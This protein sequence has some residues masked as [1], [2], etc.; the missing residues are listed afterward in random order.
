M[1]GPLASA[2]RVPVRRPWA[3]LAGL[4]LVAALGAPALARGIGTDFGLEQLLPRG[5][6]EFE[7][8]RALGER[9]GKD[10]GTVF[11]FVDDPALLTPLGARQVVA[12]SDA[13]AAGPWVEEVSG[14]AT[15]TLVEDEGDVLRVGPCLDRTRLDAPGSGA[16]GEA[17]DYARLRARL[18]TDPAYADR[19]L[20]RDGRTAAFA[21][22]LLPAWT[23]DAH[24]R[25]V[26]AGVDAVVARFAA[27]GRQLF[28][29]GSP[30]TR[31]AYVRFLLRDTA[32]F[33]GLC[34]LVLALA[35]AVTFRS[36]LGVA[37]PLVAVL[38]ALYF[39]GVIFALSGLRLS[40]LSSAI[41][42]L[43]LITG[44]SDAIHLLSRY[45]EELAAHGPEGQ[46]VDGATK[47]AALE[48]AV[49]ATAHACLLTSITTSTGFFLLPTTGIPM[50]GETGVIVGAGVLLAYAVT[51]TLLPALCAVLPAPRPRPPEGEATLL[52]RL[53]RVAMDRPRT[54]IAACLAG[55][56]LLLGLG[57]PRLRV[58]SRVV[59][60]LPDEHPLLQNRRA[61]EERFGGN[62]P[63]TLVVT[64]TQGPA[65]DP[66]LIA[67]VA[68]FQRALA[69]DD[70]RSASGGDLLSR[71]L[72][73]ADLLASVWRELGGAGLPDTPEAVA[74]TALVIGDDAFR[75]LWDGER[76]LLLIEAR[77][78]DRG[79][80]ATLAFAEQARAAFA[81]TVGARGALEVQGF[82]PLAHR[83]HR[84]VAL[85]TLTGFGLDFAIVAGLVWLLFR[86]GRLT[87]LA[88]LPNLLPLVCTLGVMG[89]LGIDLRISSSIVF[90]V[91]FGIAV[92][93]TVH[94][95]ARYHEERGGGLLPR[96]AAARTIATT[97]RAMLT[98]A[99]V[100]AAGFAVLC[101]SE[102][103]P[104]RVLGLLMAVTVGSGLVGDLILLP[105]L[106]VLGDRA[107]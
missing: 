55:A 104:N 68:S 16:R 83:V 51:L 21:V 103:T 42:V 107:K 46:R 92:D 45:G 15:T 95:L 94:F 33:T 1:S 69:A 79:T 71:T 47:L 105:A 38:L 89:L 99:V 53:G 76:D 61:V 3:T 17:I 98:M 78:H 73:P 40:L 57:A 84:D 34:S 6:P 22:Q 30:H 80:A 90:C 52:A 29:T 8:Y 54:A 75:R 87:L 27:P 82:T 88:A 7:R 44:I 58:E 35:L 96:E 86:S 59:D 74:Q 93:D 97:G 56:G 11:V 66:A 23:D 31:S 77:V 20:S 12:L 101:F 37:L 100:L 102:F 5:D 81:R 91:V 2:L 24:R 10:D 60:D 70:R 85:G 18:T 36:A 65:D 67:A 9:F 19:V 39:T 50:L 4:A 49:A 26:V 48:R 72:S 62:F 41:T 13:L 106:L 63:V 28:V 14:L 32:L 64:P 43:V 25:E